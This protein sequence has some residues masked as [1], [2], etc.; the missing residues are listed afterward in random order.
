MARMSFEMVAVKRCFLA[1]LFAPLLWPTACQAMLQVFACEPEW[2]S[3]VE[4]LAG[5]RATVFTATTALQDVHH[6]QARPSLIARARRAHLVVCTGAGLEAGWLPLL[7]RRAG[8]TGIQPGTGGYFEASQYV[9]MLDTPLSVDRTEGDIHARGNPH[10]HLDPRNITPIARALTERLAA[11]EPEHAAH[12]QSRL[13]EFMRRWQDALGVWEKRAQ[14]LNGVTVVVH[15]NSWVYL[16]HW[17]GLEQ[18]ATLEP[19]PG[20][21]PTSRHLAQLRQQLQQAPAKMV[22]RSPYQDTRA[23]E[24]LHEHTGIAM[25]ELPYTVGGNRDARDLFGLFDSTIAL[26]LEEQQ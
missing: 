12:Y 1:L 14:P 13:A 6:I 17:L 16:N 24:W 22:I 2:A 9:E 5:D 4:E 15:H 3:L 21:P 20:V 7:L 25:I 8:N 18:V 11:I 19:K 10:I 26:L 23:S